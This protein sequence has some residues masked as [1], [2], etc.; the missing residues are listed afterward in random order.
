VDCVRTDDIVVV[1]PE[2]L[3]GGWMRRGDQVAISQQEE[4]FGDYS[5]GRW[6]WLLEDIKPLAVPVPA[7]GALSLWEWNQEGHVPA[8]QT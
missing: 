7:R 3:L 4:L 1:A 5:R 6:A 2:Q 8:N